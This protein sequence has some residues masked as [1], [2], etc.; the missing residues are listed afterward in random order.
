MT[1]LDE[2]LRVNADAI[3]AVLSE[4]GVENSAYLA[5]KIANTLDPPNTDIDAVSAAAYYAALDLSGP[6]NFTREAIFRAKLT[7]AAMLRA[8]DAVLPIADLSEARL[9]EVYDKVTT[10]REKIRE[11]DDLRDVFQL[12]QEAKYGLGGRINVAAT[13]RNSQAPLLARRRT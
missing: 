8:L 5:V 7:R 11:R 6:Y 4:E 12:L 13:I 10:A 1:E 2:V 3:A 9:A